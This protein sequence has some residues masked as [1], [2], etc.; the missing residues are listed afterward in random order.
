[1]HDAA[2]ARSLGVSRAAIG[3]A[4]RRLANAPTRKPVKPRSL[5]NKKWIERALKLVNEIEDWGAMASD[6]LGPEMDVIEQIFKEASELRKLNP[7]TL[8]ADKKEA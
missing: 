4:R 7:L 3:K 5:S 1:M 2:I 6:D 8:N